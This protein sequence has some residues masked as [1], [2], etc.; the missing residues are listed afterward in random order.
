MGVFKEHAYAFDEVAK[1]SKQIWNDA[2]DYGCPY[3][4]KVSPQW[5]KDLLRCVNDLKESDKKYPSNRPF[6]R[7]R[8]EWKNGVKLVIRIAWEVD[9][10]MNYGTEYT[11][12]YNFLGTRYQKQPSALWKGC[13]AFIS[14]DAVRYREPSEEDNDLDPAGGDGLYSHI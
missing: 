5:I 11:I 6:I 13:N 14:V 3:N 8:E 12:S 10:G 4:N 2:C 1:R 7:N 9:E